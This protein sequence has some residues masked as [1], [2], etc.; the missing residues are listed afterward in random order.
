MSVSLVGLFLSRL[1]PVPAREAY[2]THV[3]HNRFPQG[4]LGKSR[5]TVKSL[6]EHATQFGFYD[7]NDIIAHPNQDS[8]VKGVLLMIP[9][10]GKYTSG[11]LQVYGDL[12]PLY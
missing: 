2:F 6:W 11:G 8:R 3:Y 7:G 5:T 9:Q 10:D 12:W 1:R 4:A